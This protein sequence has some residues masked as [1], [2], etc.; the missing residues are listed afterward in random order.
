MPSLQDKDEDEE[1]IPV[2]QENKDCEEYTVN[3]H[4][5]F[6]WPEKELVASYTYT[7]GIYWL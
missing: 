2:C 6:V 3:T 7:E 5:P 1:N 4:F